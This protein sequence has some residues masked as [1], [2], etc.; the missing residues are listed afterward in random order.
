MA[1]LSLRR[2]R[3][4]LLW[5]A[6]VAVWMAVTV[7]V[8]DKVI[9]HLS[10]E[11]GELLNAMVGIP[12]LAGFIWLFIWGMAR[13]NEMPYVPTS[14][15]WRDVGEILGGCAGMVFVLVMMLVSLVVLIWLVKT[16]WYVV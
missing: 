5:L 2:L 14:P 16:I 7:T 13:Q 15:F 4:P 1:A 11:S 12:W 8:V 9:P 3:R 6:A 10:K